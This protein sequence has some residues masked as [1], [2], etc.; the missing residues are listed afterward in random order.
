MNVGLDHVTPPFVD[1]TRRYWSSNCSPASHSDWFCSF[2]NATKTVPSGATV[3][4]ENWSS[5]QAPAGPDSWNVQSAAFEP[6]ISC[7]VDQ[8]KPPSSECDSKIG[9]ERYSPDAETN[10]VQVRYERP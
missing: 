3:G 1:F 6:E 9:D 4:T 7:G 2:S 5:S 8:V 10:F